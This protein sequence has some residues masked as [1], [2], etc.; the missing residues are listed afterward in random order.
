MKLDR[1]VLNY[2]EAQKILKWAYRSN[3]SIKKKNA[4]S[5]LNSFPHNDI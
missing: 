3:L 5:R 1:T 4:I 2:K